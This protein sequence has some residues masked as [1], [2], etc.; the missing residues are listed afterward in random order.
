MANG[1]L[2]FL[3]E[4][5]Y[6]FFNLFS[7][8]QFRPLYCG[9]IRFLIEQQALKLITFVSRPHTTDIQRRDSHT[10]FNAEYHYELAPTQHSMQGHQTFF[11][12]R[13]S[14]GILVTGW[15]LSFLPVA[16]FQ[17]SSLE[18][19]GARRCSRSSGRLTLIV[20]T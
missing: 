18:A 8:E 10:L 1:Y 3:K 15:Y 2:V 17:G 7:G 9:K 16:R 4:N 5:H 12:F 6:A 14:G 13:G 19:P 11:G 20:S